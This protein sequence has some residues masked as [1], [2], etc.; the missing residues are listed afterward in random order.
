MRPHE[1]TWELDG[2][3]DVRRTGARGR[4]SLVCL[5]AAT[6]TL[7]AQAL[8]SAA[9]EITRALLAMRE[10]Y[11]GEDGASAFENALLAADAVL[12]KAGAPLP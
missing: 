6:G 2:D 4:T 10:A 3:G 5:R 9:P 12:A 8:I 1:E 11:L 7:E